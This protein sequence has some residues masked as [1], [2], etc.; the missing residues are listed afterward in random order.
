[1]LDIWCQGQTEKESKDIT[2]VKNCWTQA[3]SF[4]SSSDIIM[5]LLTKSQLLEIK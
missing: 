1:M 4:L 2:G 5:D 3:T